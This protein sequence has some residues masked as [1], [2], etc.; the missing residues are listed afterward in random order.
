LH[1]VVFQ[2]VSN[3]LGCSTDSVQL[4]AIESEDVNKPKKAIEESNKGFQ[5]LKGMGWRAGQGLGKNNQGI[6]GPVCY[7]Q[8]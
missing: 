8:S 7:V 3:L 1:N 5:L 2:F 4:R 6:Q